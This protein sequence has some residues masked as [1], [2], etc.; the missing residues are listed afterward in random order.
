MSRA[1]IQSVGRRV[2]DWSEK[3]IPSPF[4]FAIVL[5]IVA[6]LA[7]LV[8]TNDGPYQNLVNWYDGFWSLLTFAMQMVLILV[9]GYA[10]AD[11]ELVSGYLDRLASIPDT[12]A[13]AAALVAAVAMAAGYFHW[14]IGLI[15]GAIFAIFVARAGHRQGYTF[16]YP[17]LCAAGYTSQVIWHAGPSSSAGL[18]SATE[19]HVFVDVIGVVPLSASVFTVYAVGL[20]LAVFLTVL[21]TMYFLAPDESDAVGIDE[22]APSLLDTGVE[23][24]EARS[25][26]GERGDVDDRP[27]ED[28]G[29]VE[30]QTGVADR[31]AGEL[32][33]A[34]RI[35][36]SPAV[37]YLI[38]AAMLV[39]VV[40]YFASAGSVGEALDFNVFNFTF[41]ALGLALHGTP[42][43]YMET[44]RDA[45]EGAAGIVVQFPFYAGIL[46]IISNSGLSDIISEVVLGVATAETFPVVAWLLGGVMNLFVPSG[47]GEWA[48]IGGIVGGT[49]VELGVPPGKAIVAYGAGDM[50]TN[51]FQPF[52]AIPL[53]G[54]TRI[55]ARDILGYTVIVM[56]VLTPVFALAL[57]FLPYWS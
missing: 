26:P 52:W 7:A 15:V 57:Y 23:D 16:H 32:L 4:I 24:G 10:V 41:I 49:A 43:E 29:E 8:L 47:G 27:V 9:S 11:S 33:P 30:P 42:R 35:N 25:D 38:S 36:D 31:P 50:W 3:W 14:G 21:P 44:I 17:V 18:L 45:T 19:D 5:T 2:A 37:A 20:A 40:S 12:N 55:R 34:D 1:S 6:Y 28:G 51:M 56:V 53:L 54:L 39:Y 46:G 48:I 13:G 22:Y